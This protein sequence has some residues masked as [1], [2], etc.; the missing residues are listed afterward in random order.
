MQLVEV[1]YLISL[2]F[3]LASIFVIYVRIRPERTFLVSYLTGYLV[4]LVFSNLALVMI[5][6]GWIAQFPHF[7]KLMMP[8]S[9]LSPVI[10]YW[11]VKGSLGYNYSW[12]TIDY[13][14]L[15]PFI[16]VA[17]HYMPFYFLSAEE[18]RPLVDAVI[19]E[20]AALINYSYGFIFTESQVYLLRTF[21]A[22]VYQTLSHLL[23]A[24]FIKANPFALLSSRSKTVFRWV[25]FFVW[26]ITAYL[27]SL[28][29]CYALNSMRFQGIALNELIEQAVFL[30]TAGFVFVLSSHL[31]MHPRILLTLD[32]TIEHQ[33]EDYLYV[34]LEAVKSTVVKQGWYENHQLTQPLLVEMLGLKIGIFAKAIKASRFE[35]FNDFMNSIRLEQFVRRATPSDLERNSIEGIANQVG[36][37]SSTTFFRV[38]KENFGTTPKEYLK[39]KQPKISAKH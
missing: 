14:H 30:L 19:A 28:I 5:T 15:L 8:F 16:A 1:I 38:F 32:H 6:T 13:A 23:L 9:L 21:Q 2:A 34:D 27:V 12:R 24:K 18:K 20:D 33:A 7:Y 10:S 39:R 17:L 22:I 25:R 36:F 3:A 4:I 11:Y 35:N 29:L 26:A 37:K 31:L